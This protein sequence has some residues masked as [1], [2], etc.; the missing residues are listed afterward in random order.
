MEGTIRSRLERGKPLLSVGVLTADLLHLDDDLARLDG[1]GVELLH[2]DVMDGCFCPAMTVGPPFI[3]QVSRRGYLKDVHLMIEDPHLKV[4]EYVEAGADIVTVHAEA[5][6]TAHRALQALAELENRNDPERGI[7]RGV[8]FNPGTPVAALEPLLELA[9]LVVVVAINPGWGGQKLT[10]AA[11][12]RVEAVR[13]L[14]ERTGSSALVGLDGA[15]KRSNIEAV[16]DWGVDLV[17][18]GSAVFDGKDVTANARFMV[19][20]M[21]KGRTSK[22]PSRRPAGDGFEV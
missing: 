12:R 4:A 13:E 6:W 2:F 16:A 19:E 22:V 10:D 15:I 20:A 17:V 21:N 7:L 14:L 1:T 18:S 5:G 8:A 3:R 11:R 9:D